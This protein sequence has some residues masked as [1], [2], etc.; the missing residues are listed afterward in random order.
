MSDEDKQR[1]NAWLDD[2]N[3]I[4]KEGEGRHD[5][6]KFKIC[7]YFW[8]YADEWLNLSDDERFDK[9]LAMAP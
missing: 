5:V 1:F 6:T 7:S 8:K 4:I 9:G 2:D 3:T